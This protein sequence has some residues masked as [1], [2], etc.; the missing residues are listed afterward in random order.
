MPSGSG[1]P[2]YIDPELATLLERLP[3]VDLH[4]HLV[5]AMRAATLAELA[6]KHAI[7]LP[8]SVGARGTPWS[9]DSPAS[10]PRGRIRRENASCAANSCRI[11]AC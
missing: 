1:L 2:P 10:R 8:K 6:A 7:E 11:S 3:K 5:G 4:L 9:W